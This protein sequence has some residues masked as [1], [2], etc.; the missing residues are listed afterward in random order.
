MAKGEQAAT[1]MFQ[2]YVNFL[3]VNTKYAW[4]KI[5]HKQ[6]HLTPIQT[7]KAVPRKDPGGFCASHLMT[8]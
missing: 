3:S 1:D 5:I 7:S 4:N 2:L 6:T 8:A